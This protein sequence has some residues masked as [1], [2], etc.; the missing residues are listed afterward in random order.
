MSD[1]RDSDYAD[2]RRRTA[3]V[4]AELERVIDRMEELGRQAE[5]AKARVTDA[6]P[7]C[8]TPAPALVEAIGD[9]IE[10]VTERTRLAHEA[11]RLMIQL[12]ADN[13]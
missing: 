5:D 1:N 3:P 7:A 2:E 13:T 10:I 6:I 8:Q 9:V 11:R 4:I 12:R